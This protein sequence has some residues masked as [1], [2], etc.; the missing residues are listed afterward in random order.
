VETVLVGIGGGGL[1][2]GIG[3]AVRAAGAEVRVVGVQAAGA[4]AFV[5]SVRAG[6]LVTVAA[7]T[8][9]DGMA[10]SR[11]GSRTLELAAELVDEVVTVDEAAFWEAMALLWARGHQAEPAGVAGIAALLRRPDLACG[12]TAVVVSG[13]NLDVTTAGRVAE[14]AQPYQPPGGAA[15]A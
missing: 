1:A 12:T 6:Q 2:C 11:P 15:A 10:V 14:L 9:A 13:G 7:D 4:P 5:A 3:A 8:V